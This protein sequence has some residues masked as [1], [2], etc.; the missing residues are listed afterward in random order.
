MA[1]FK[2]TLSEWR[3]WVGLGLFGIGT[4][5]FFNPIQDWLVAH[6]STVFQSTLAIMGLGAA[7]VIVSMYFFKVN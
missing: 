7:I 3:S 5:L 1:K 2:I 4:T 6:V